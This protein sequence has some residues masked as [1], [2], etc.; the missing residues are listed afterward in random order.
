MQGPVSRDKKVV[1][2]V[3]V[4]APPNATKARQ[5]VGSSQSLSSPYRPPASR[6]EALKLGQG[7]GKILARKV[8]IKEVVPVLSPSSVNLKS[9]PSP[10]V[11]TG[12]GP[13]GLGVGSSGSGVGILNSA[14]RK[15]KQLLDRRALPIPPVSVPLTSD[16]N[17][18]G[19]R[20]KDASL[21]GC[22][23]RRAPVPTQ[24]NR[25]DFFNALRRKAGLDS[26]LNAVDKSDVAPSKINA[27][28]KSNEVGSAM[29]EESVNHLME[30]VGEEDP[31]VDPYPSENGDRH[32]NDTTLDAE[33]PVSHIELFGIESKENGEIMEGT[34][35]DQLFEDDITFMISL[36]WNKARVEETDALTQDE[37]DAFFQKVFPQSSGPRVFVHHG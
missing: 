31:L 14:P 22:D 13:P 29:P 6:P 32:E 37:I 1:R 19:L 21:S 3:D 20:S 28:V 36:G 12:V 8:S 35:Y 24:T 26:T 9:D 33:E 2:A 5:A 4:V 23:E 17:A 25:V 16:G 27:V 18:V 30:V 15:Q 7:T 11:S 10:S 34:T